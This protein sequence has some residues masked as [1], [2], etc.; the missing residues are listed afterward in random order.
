MVKF[1]SSRLR[2]FT[3]APAFTLQKKTDHMDV[4]LNTAKNR[5][6]GPPKGMRPVGKRG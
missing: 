6:F 5:F 1:L 4:G 2:Y 3:K